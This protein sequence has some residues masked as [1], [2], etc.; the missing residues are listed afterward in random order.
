MMQRSG[1]NEHQQA[2]EWKN[3]LNHRLVAQD[4]A[5]H[6]E[7]DGCAVDEQAERR[8]LRMSVVAIHEVIALE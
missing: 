6:E 3:P 7:H 8:S 2:S 4:A 1:K 5:Q